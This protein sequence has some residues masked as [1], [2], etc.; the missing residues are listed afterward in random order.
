MFDI[1]EVAGPHSSGVYGGEIDLGG[2]AAP[3]AIDGFDVGEPEFG[4]PHQTELGG[5]VELSALIGQFSKELRKESARP[6]WFSPRVVAILL[7]GLGYLVTLVASVARGE[8]NFG[9][10]W[11]LAGAAMLGA[12]VG[13][14]NGV[15]YPKRPP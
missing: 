2:Q 14:P 1:T 5:C 11:G 6:N 9:D 3:Q 8:L 7:F 13:R 10:F 4:L 15:N 12:S